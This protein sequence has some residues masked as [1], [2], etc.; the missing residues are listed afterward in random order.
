MLNM[1]KVRT[2]S[3]SVKTKAESGLSPSQLNSCGGSSG[4]ANDSSQFEVTEDKIASSSSVVFGSTASEIL[5]GLSI[6]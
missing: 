3:P 4:D 5:V 2:P 6:V 1:P